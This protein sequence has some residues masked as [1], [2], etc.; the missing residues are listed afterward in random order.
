M[1]SSDALPPQEIATRMRQALTG[2]G[3]PTLSTFLPLV[4]QFSKSQPS[5]ESVAE[6]EEYLQ[7]ISTSSIDVNNTLQFA[8]FVSTLHALLPVLPPLSVITTWFDL[9]LRSSFRTP[10]LPRQ[11]VREAKELVLHGLSDDAHPKTASFRRM[12]IDLYLLD[13]VNESSKEDM[14]EHMAMDQAEQ[15]RQRCWKENLEETLLA[16]AIQRPKELFSQLDVAFQNPRSRLQLMAL[17]SQ[18]ARI[19]EL[20]VTDLAESQ[21][22]SSLLTSLQ[23]DLSTT[24]VSVGISVLIMLLP[25]MAWKSPKVLNDSLPRLLS[26]L[27]R[28][29]CWKERAMPLAQPMSATIE[30]STFFVGSGSDT[31]TEVPGG[32]SASPKLAAD[33]TWTRLESSFDLQAAAPAP[34]ARLYFQFLYGLWPT[35]VLSFL[36]RPIKMLQTFGLKSPYTDDWDEIIDEDEVRS[37]IKPVLRTHVIHPSIILLDSAAEMSDYTR[38]N[39]DGM[40]VAGLVS[41]CISLDVKNAAAAL[42]GRGGRKHGGGGTSGTKGASTTTVDLALPPPVLSPG[43]GVATP[44]EA[45]K[46]VQAVQPLRKEESSASMIGPLPG[47]EHEIIEP[48]TVDPTNRNPSPPIQELVATHVALKSSAVEP[49]TSPPIQEQVSASSAS[50]SESQTPDVTHLSPRLHYVD[51]ESGGT[52]DPNTPLMQPGSPPGVAASVPVTPPIGPS[53]R[54]RFKSFGGIA[55][56][57]GVL[58]VGGSTV[59]VT[60]TSNAIPISAGVGVLSVEPH[61]AISS[62]Q[63]EVLLLRNELNFELWLK[64]Q[65]LSHMGKLHRDRIVARSEEAERQN[66]YNRVRATSKMLQQARDELKSLKLESASAKAKQKEYVDYLQDKLTKHREE[67]KSWASE[68]TELRG[69]VIEAKRMVEKQ[70]AIMDETENARFNLQN[71]LDEVMPK[72]MQIRDYEKKIEDMT[73][74]QLMWDDSPEMHEYREQKDRMQAIL[75]DN[76]K[77]ELTIQSLEGSNQALEELN[78]EQRRLLRSSEGRAISPTGSTHRHSR[79]FANQSPVSI[80]SHERFLQLETEHLEVKSQKRELEEKVEEL[81]AMVEVLRAEMHRAGRRGSIHT[82]RSFI[83]DY[84]SSSGSFGS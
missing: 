63:R 51:F 61:H 4:A 45:L 32:E 47:D 73:K 23:L 64:K 44:K 19:P 75:S 17:L 59:D 49:I 21:L 72:V 34:D 26:I 30:T 78:N 42:P 84:G 38:W 14:I 18:L 11:S 62:L 43:S 68:A 1:A 77:L 5:P 57:G 2:G 28:V 60:S 13:V 53:P 36:R 33:V 20:S 56:F 27:C 82:P 74:R 50:I 80:M 55:E 69:E 81:E 76:A 12:L 66:L 24:L 15:E 70:R 7:E 48:P 16:D 52:S 10:K 37:R 3:D 79:S 58:G 40:D 9:V 71:Q 25:Q 29:I 41:Q 65:H 8:G 6:L 46:S 54:L 39:T 67:K 83:P 35:T 31:A 22:Y